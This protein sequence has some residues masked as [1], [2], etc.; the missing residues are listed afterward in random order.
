MCRK[1]SEK[2][3]KGEA[4][5]SG[6]YHQPFAEWK[7][8]GTPNAFMTFSRPSTNLLKSETSGVRRYGR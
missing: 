8:I 3:M 4:S 6:K 5:R 7:E 2:G 1:R